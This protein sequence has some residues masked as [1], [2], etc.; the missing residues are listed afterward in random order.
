MFQPSEDAKVVRVVPR[1]V[2]SWSWASIMVAN[3]KEDVGLGIKFKVALDFLPES[4][5]QILGADST[6][7]CA[8]PFGQVSGGLLILHGMSIPGIIK[9]GP[10]AQK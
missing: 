4:S 6:V 7:V 9:I 3:E 8:N 1:R 5:F 2:P 10:V